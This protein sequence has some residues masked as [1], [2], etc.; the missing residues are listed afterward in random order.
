MAGTRDRITTATNELFRRRGYHDTSLKD[1]VAA[2]GAT[3]GSLYHFFPGGKAELAEAVLIGSGAAYQALF[4]SIYDEAGSPEPAVQAFFD[5]AADVLEATDFVDL[6]PIATVA[7][8][9]SSTDD[10]LRRATAQVFASWTEALA[11]R[12]RDAGV[13]ADDAEEVATTVV[14]TLEGSFVL[15]RSRRDADVVRAAGR[16]TQPLLRSVLPRAGSRRR[17]ARSRR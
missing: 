8:E 9:V 6:C 1:V 14:A 2:S 4:E 5:G 11:L 7:A 15:A 3:T 17:T 16:R 10:R 13:G 12:L